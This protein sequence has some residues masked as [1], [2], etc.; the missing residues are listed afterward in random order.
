M[1]CK[2]CIKELNA[3][4]DGSLPDG[5]RVQVNDHL[6]NCIECAAV[7]RMQVVAD[8]VIEDEKQVQSNPFLVTRIMA[9]I[10][11]METPISAIVHIPSYKR[12][13]KPMLVAVSIIVAVLVGVSAGNAYQS[14]KKTSA[15]PV[16]L[17]YM[18]DAALESVDFLTN[19]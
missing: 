11:A 6:A 9:N 19:N 18:N 7:Y 5:I 4:H 1:N 14:G 3:Y 10:E 2:L 15:I 13:L 12:V 17:S 16:E 8:K